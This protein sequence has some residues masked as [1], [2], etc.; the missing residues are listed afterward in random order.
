[1]HKSTDM[2]SIPLRKAFIHLNTVKKHFELITIDL[3]HES[4]FEQLLEEYD[5][6]LNVSQI[7]SETP[8]NNSQDDMLDLKNVR[9][10]QIPYR[11]KKIRLKLLKHKKH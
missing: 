10:I 3:S 6:A 5:L 7:D 1:M 4:N 2:I 11:K 9:V 8:N